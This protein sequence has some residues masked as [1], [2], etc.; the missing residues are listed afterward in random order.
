MRVSSG[1]RAALTLRLLGAALVILAAA[2][3]SSRL[4]GPAACERMAVVLI[5]EEPHTIKASPAKSR[6]LTIVTHGCLTTPF[7]HQAVRCVEETRGL[8]RCMDDLAWRIP[9]RKPS[10][11]RFMTRALAP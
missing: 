7:D 1:P 3:C 2:A 8:P 10:I 4:P 6:F 5:G 11:R 9:S